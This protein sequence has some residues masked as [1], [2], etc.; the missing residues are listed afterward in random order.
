MSKE[1]TPRVVIIGGGPGGLTLARILQRR[2]MPVTLYEHD[3]SKHARDQGGTLDLHPESGQSALQIAGLTDEFE[4][5]ARYE[6]QDFRLLDKH[7]TIFL[8]EIAGPESQRPEVDR[9][10]LRE[11]L[12][13]S[14]HPD[15]IVWDHT[16]HHVTALD[17]GRYE[18]AFTN[19]HTD[20][21]DLLIGADGAWSRVRPLLSDA[22]PGY[23]GVSFVEIG[24]SNVE[25]RHPD[26][27]RLVGR[28]SL[29]ALSDQKGLIAQRNAYDSIRVYIALRVPA[30]WVTDSGIPFD[31]PQKARAAL[32]GYF[33]DWT[34]ELTNLIRHCD[35]RFTPRPLLMLPIHHRW[36]HR[37]GIT[38]LGDA[39]HLMSPF[40]GEGANQ[41]MLD[42]TELALVLTSSSDFN[43]AI[44]TYETTMFQR[45]SRAAEE[46]ARNLDE[47]FADDAPRGMLA[48]MLRSTQD[49]L[50]L[51]QMEVRS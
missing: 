3:A 13:N 26:L 35:D 11:L 15:T 38:L 17:D 36:H 45:A 30:S 40:A 18:L 31:H 41:A 8:D 37:P 23:T 46:S 16:L 49:A 5:I 44:A 42:A 43:T 51:D 48:Q 20:T 29:F 9:G 21:A 50:P 33:T 47:S 32:L 24:L 25:Q 28:G 2:G 4:A 7:G 1:R 22:T 19:G 14:L 27:A 6:G 39:A 12:L 10:A 34:D